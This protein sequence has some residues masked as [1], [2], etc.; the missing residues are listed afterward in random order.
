MAQHPVADQMVMQEYY[1]A[2][3]SNF[4][5]PSEIRHFNNT[6]TAY[7]VINALL[8]TH[9]EEE[10]LQENLDM[11]QQMQL[12]FPEII[13][14]MERTNKKRKLTVND[15]NKNL[16]QLGI[17]ESFGMKPANAVDIEGKIVSLY[18]KNCRFR[19]LTDFV[20]IIRKNNILVLKD[21][22]NRQ[23]FHDLSTRRFL[24]GLNYDVDDK[25]QYFDEERPDMKKWL[26]WKPFER[27]FVAKYGVDIESCQ[28]FV[29]LLIMQSTKNTVLKNTKEYCG[30]KNY[31]ANM[32]EHYTN[33]FY[34]RDYE[35]LMKPRD[36]LELIDC[37]ALG[38]VIEQKEAG[39]VS[40]SDAIDFWI[41]SW[42]FRVKVS[43]TNGEILPESKS[44]IPLCKD[45]VKSVTSEF[46][47]AERL[48]ERS[49]HYLN[50][51]W[52]SDFPF[53]VNPGFFYRENDT[54]EH[55]NF[56]ISDEAKEAHK[57]YKQEA[58]E[59]ESGLIPHI[60]TLFTIKRNPRKRLHIE[61]SDSE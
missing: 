41:D 32:K 17:F 49:I 50:F 37:F 44:I 31:A 36:D 18:L 8:Y 55:F 1:I 25:V 53:H 19:L 33:L 16:K 60:D 2:Y 54:R 43:G 42:K 20:S 13:H 38:P 56:R 6:Q 22:A 27:R 7:R 46:Y 29:T 61:I 15:S 48:Y 11:Y 14:P 34:K 35:M 4:L 12:P 59:K 5:A 23:L 58:I 39:G 21:V 24:A 51:I 3:F 28:K 52:H 9:E 47:C 10:Q 40:K 45:S 57:K 26:T 30:L